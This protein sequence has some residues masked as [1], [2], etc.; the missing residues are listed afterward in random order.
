MDD[1]RQW[2]DQPLTMDDAGNGYASVL[3]LLKKKLAGFTGLMGFEKTN[4]G[5]SEKVIIHFNI[6]KKYCNC[7][8]P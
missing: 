6:Y 5:T 2:K 7:S 4:L 3:R 1:G 8:A